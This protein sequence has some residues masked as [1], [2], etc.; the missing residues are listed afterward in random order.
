MTLLLSRTTRVSP[1]YFSTDSS[2]TVEGEKPSTGGTPSPDLEKAHKELLAKKDSEIQELKDSYRRAL[3]DAENLRH[4][5]QKEL[6]DKTAYAI[7]SFAKDLLTTA[8]TLSLALN[9]VPEHERG[10]KATH[11]ELKNLWV[12]VMLTQ[13]ELLKTFQSVRCFSYSPHHR[14]SKHCKTWNQ[15]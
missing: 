12:G 10:E 5:T 11:K 2:S 8:D 3:A 15:H 14:V 1:R 9:A 13:K 7:Q 6:A 4:R